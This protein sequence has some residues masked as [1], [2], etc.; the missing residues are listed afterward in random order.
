MDRICEESND[1]LQA[2]GKIA[3]A[4]LASRFNLPADFISK[5]LC[6]MSL[7]LFHALLLVIRATC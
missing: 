1:V 4:E 5:V 3:V 2:E 6:N 7:L